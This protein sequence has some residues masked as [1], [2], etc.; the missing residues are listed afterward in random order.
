MRIPKFSDQE[1]EI[2]FKHDYID[3]GMVKWQG[4]YLSDHTS[5]LNAEHET[6]D[7]VL[8][9]EVSPQMTVKEITDVIN[10]AIVKNKTV[11]IQTNKCDSN[12]IFEAPIVGKISGYV[13]SELY[14]NIKTIV[15][16]D[17]IRSIIFM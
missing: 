1:A 7:K 14:I 3:R 8:Q 11:K 6:K 2:F 5:A 17:M 16:I 12:G 13:S 9:R 10:K 15:K 4:F